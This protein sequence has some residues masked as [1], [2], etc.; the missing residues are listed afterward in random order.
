MAFNNRGAAWIQRTKPIRNPYF[1]AKMLQ[2][3]TIK[4]TFDGR[5]GQPLTTSKRFLSRLSPIYK[6]YLAIQHQLFRDQ[7]PKSKR[8]AQTLYRLS[9]PSLSRYAPRKA[10]KRWN[11]LQRQLIKHA[12]QATKSKDLKTLRI[13]FGPLSQTLL[14]MVYVFGH[15]LPKPLFEA[16]CP[17]AFNNRGAAWVQDQDRRVHN[18]YFGAQMAY[19]GNIRRTFEARKP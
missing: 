11:T 3:G 1:G 16:Y 19:C 9:R 15:S 6:A 8:A 14:Q 18:S 10:R 2:C 13:H 12:R 4:R 5:E 17:M 7:W